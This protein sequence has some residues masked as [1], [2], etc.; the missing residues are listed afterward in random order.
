MLFSNT[1]IAQHINTYF[2]PAWEMVRSVPL[3]RIDFGNG[4]VLTRTLNGNIATYVCTAEG[5]V[6]DALPGVYTPA[7]Y[8]D[9]LEQFRLLAGYANGRG[10]ALLAARFAEYHQARAEALR[11]N[12]TPGRLVLDMMAFASK[13]KIEEP[14]KFVLNPTA[15]KQ[16]AAKASEAAFPFGLPVAAAATKAENPKLDTAED[17]AKWDALIEDTQRNETI[18]RRQVHELLAKSGLVTPDKV[19]KPLYRDIL[20][21]DLDDPYL[22]LGKTLF[23]SY[24][25]KNEDAR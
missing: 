19:V 16:A 20:H 8:L 10:P 11:K 6:L 5:Q 3:V 2:E 14:I 9:C 7:A 1:A 12:E 17:L 15:A 4:N 25:F 22:G 24:P 18:H 13:A 21:A 23:G